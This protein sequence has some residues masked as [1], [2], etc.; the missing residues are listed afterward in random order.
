MRT[1]ERV[2]EEN[3]R[4]PVSEK[5]V[6]PT[7]SGQMGVV[8]AWKL[9]EL[10]DREE[11]ANVRRLEDERLAKQIRESPAVFDTQERPQTDASPITLTEDEFE[12]A[13]DRVSRREL[14]P[15][16]EK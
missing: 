3:R 16:S 11:L 15:D 5:W 1:F 8:P 13:L 4:D 14:P 7:N 10:L 12:D 2:L 9:Q 6:V